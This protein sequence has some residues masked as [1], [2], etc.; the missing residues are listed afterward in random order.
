MTYLR[1]F[2]DFVSL[3][4]FFQKGFDPK[5]RFQFLEKLLVGDSVLLSDA[6]YMECYFV[7]WC[8]VSLTMEK[9]I[10]ALPTSQAVVETV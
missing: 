4:V 8:L 2:E 10:P 7:E 6:R 9:M 3:I 5:G 1:H